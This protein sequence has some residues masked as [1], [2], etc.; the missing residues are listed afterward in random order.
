MQQ[1]IKITIDAT[2]AEHSAK[3]IQQELPYLIEY[4]LLPLLEPVMDKLAPN[5][6]ILIFESLLAEL[7]DLNI[8]T[9]KDDFVTHAILQITNALKKKSVANHQSKQSSD[10]LAIRLFTEYLQTGLLPQNPVYADLVQIMNAIVAKWHGDNWIVNVLQDIKPCSRFI[11]VATTELRNLLETEIPLFRFKEDF[12]EAFKPLFPYFI[13]Y[14]RYLYWVEIFIMQQHILEAYKN[15]YTKPET[16]LYLTLGV[17]PETSKSIESITSILQEIYPKIKKS[18]A[19]P[20]LK[21]FEAIPANIKK[22]PE[23]ASV[24]TI[25]ADDIKSENHAASSNDGINEKGNDT[26]ERNHESINKI[27]TNRKEISGEDKTEGAEYAVPGKIENEFQ[28]LETAAA[29]KKNNTE[30]IHNSDVQPEHSKENKLPPESLEND[31]TSEFIYSENSGKVENEYDS[32]E[33]LHNTTIFSGDETSDDFKETA[34]L[35]GHGPQPKTDRL[36]NNIIKAIPNLNTPNNIERNLQAA[37]DTTPV[38]NNQDIGKA[39]SSA[40]DDETV[41]QSSHNSI[42]ES[43]SSNKPEDKEKTVAHNKG[44]ETWT[45]DGQTTVKQLNVQLTKLT[46]HS[47]NQPEYINNSGIV[48]LAPFLPQLFRLAGL[49]D[50]NSWASAYHQQKAVLLLQYIATAN[51]AISEEQLLLPKILCGCPIDEAID[52][53]IEITDNDVLL[54]E[55]MLGAVIENWKALAN[56]SVQALREG[57]LQREGKIKMTGET[58]E[59]WVENKTIDILLDRLPWSISLVRTPW[60]QN[61]LQCYWK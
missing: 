46:Q 59:L 36:S 18:P 6:Q 20:T 4:K 58:V 23:N 1:I 41:V 13:T 11:F 14:Q 39:G 32:V 56:S 30:D 35:K 52:I 5:E 22:Y 51:N 7:P 17:F 29:K 25:H 21:N 49:L 60:M 53:T 31:S 38:I 9:W 50:D 34:T 61:F 19:A 40:Y 24:K 37:E 44:D 3:K 10:Q 26:N 42:H 57:F 28:G 2:C 54:C 27:L 16:I 48:I 43:K 45:N 55:E 15:H 47:F 8:K 12:I 33:K